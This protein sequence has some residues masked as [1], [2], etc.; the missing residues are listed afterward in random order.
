VKRKEA[1]RLKKRGD[2]SFAELAA[3]LGSDSNSI[4]LAGVLE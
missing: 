2:Y 1:G 4:R 3:P